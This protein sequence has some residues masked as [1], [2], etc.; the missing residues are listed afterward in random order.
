MNTPC[1]QTTR[2]R[3]ETPDSDPWS[4][5]YDALTRILGLAVATSPPRL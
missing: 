1:I 2:T 3:Q 4:I 5:Q